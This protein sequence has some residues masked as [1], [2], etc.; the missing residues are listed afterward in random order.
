MSETSF[1]LSS[2]LTSVSID[3]LTVVGHDVGH[4]SQ[5]VNDSSFGFI[6]NS[7]FAKYPYRKQWNCF[8]GSV[9]QWSDVRE[10]TPIRFEFNPNNIVQSDENEHRQNIVKI[11][12]TMK[13][14]KVN[15]LDL[16][17]D[18]KGIDLS[19]LTV[20]DMSSRKQNEWRNGSG[21]RETLYIGG[22]TSD[23]K[24]RIYDKAVEQNDTSNGHWWRVEAQMKGDWCSPMNGELRVNGQSF[25]KCKK[26]V[27]S[28]FDD[29]KL[30]FPSLES[31]KRI[32]DRAMLAYLIENPES[33]AELSVNTRLKYKKLLASLPTDKEFDLTSIFMPFKEKIDRE[34]NY[35][36]DFSSRNDVITVTS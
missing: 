26:Q 31:V 16:A 34:L 2:F 35:W 21:K 10:I 22:K 9:V 27:F 6:K 18:F 3:R 1:E 17:L 4:F 19:G 28:P 14:P 24:I 32:Q 13:Y 25:M 5:T 29:V 11:L 7:H 30:L 8:D 12:R 36:L 20:V 23:L 33:F 15:R